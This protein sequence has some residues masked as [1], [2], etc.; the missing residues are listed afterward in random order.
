[1]AIIAEWK[2]SFCSGEVSSHIDAN[3]EHKADERCHELRQSYDTLLLD[4]TEN[5]HHC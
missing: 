3:V 2:G 4:K 1:M 5:N